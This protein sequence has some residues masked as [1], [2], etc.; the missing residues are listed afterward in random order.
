MT[1]NDEFRALS[2]M[3]AERGFHI[4]TWAP[5][6][7]KTRYLLVDDLG[8]EY[9]RGLGLS[10]AVHVFRAFLSGMEEA[11]RRAR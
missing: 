4:E 7:G 5:G 11:E 3:L 1:K 6:D 8:R 9:A 10:D 2:K